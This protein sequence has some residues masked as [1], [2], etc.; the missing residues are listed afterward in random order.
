MTIPSIAVRPFRW[1]GTAPARYG[2]NARLRSRW[3]LLPP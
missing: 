3:P 1:A 2:E